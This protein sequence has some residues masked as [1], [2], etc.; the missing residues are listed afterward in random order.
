MNLELELKKVG[1][2]DKEARVY[3]ALLELGSSPVQAVAQKAEVNR[4]T[5]YVVL[6]SLMKKGIVSTVEKG[7]KTHYAAENP[8]ALLRLFRLQE[9]EIQE[10]EAEFK[11]AL[12]ELDAIFNLAGE[13]P[14]VR[15]FEGKAGLLAMQEDFLAS[16]VKEFLAVYPADEF[17]KIFTEEERK[18]YTALREKL[19]ISVRTIYTRTDG[20]VKDLPIKGEWV[21]LAKDRFPFSSDVT[22]YGDRVAF[23]A[24]K[25]KLMGVIIDSDQI[26]HTLRLIFELAWQKAKESQV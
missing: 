25:G 6:E 21:F 4:A 9:K 24:L 7:K 10:K 20:P 17:Q 11:N 26:A 13:K 18:R 12:P 22:I 23:V 8:S 16:R 14:R 19:G 2:S 1:F 5:T 15:Y 3:L